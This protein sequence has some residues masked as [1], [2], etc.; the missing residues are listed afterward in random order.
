V[1][2]DIEA[3]HAEMQLLEGVAR[4]ISDRNSL[5]IFADEAFNRAEHAALGISVAITGVVGW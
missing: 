2:K 3:C 5:E 1:E 4:E